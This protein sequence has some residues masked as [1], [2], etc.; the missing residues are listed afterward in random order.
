MPQ[1]VYRC[2]KCQADFTFTDPNK[3][4]D[5]YRECEIHEKAC[6]GVPTMATNVNGKVV[7]WSLELPNQTQDKIICD[8][9]D[10]LSKPYNPYD[11]KSKASN[12]T[13]EGEREKLVKDIV[14]GIFKELTSNTVKM[15]ATVSRF[16]AEM[17]HQVRVQIFRTIMKKE[18]GQRS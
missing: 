6:K 17:I 15:Q 10:Q 3:W 16:V 9:L 12:W 13:Y 11:P 2:T 4:L 14:T 7:G 5:V 18:N 1:I 8:Y